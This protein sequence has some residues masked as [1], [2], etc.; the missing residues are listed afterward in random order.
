MIFIPNNSKFHKLYNYISM[1]PQLSLDSENIEDFIFLNDLSYTSTIPTSELDNNIFLEKKRLQREKSLHDYE[2]INTFNTEDYFN[3]IKE[4]FP[5]DAK[6]ESKWESTCEKT[7][8]TKETKEY[9]INKLFKTNKIHNRG[10]KN[11]NLNNKQTHDKYSWDNIITKIQVH[12]ISFIINLA[13]DIIKTVSDEKKYNKTLCFKNIEYKSKIYYNYKEF[14][15][16]KEKCI[17]DILV[18]PAS[19]RNNSNKDNYNEEIYNELINSSDPSE[20]LDEFF[21]IDYLSLTHDYY[22]NCQEL[23]SITIKNKKIELS[24]KTKSFFWLINKKQNDNFKMKK[25]MIECINKVFLK[26]EKK[27]KIENNDSKINLF[28]ITK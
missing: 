22:N 6:L 8:E 25:L 17:K 1:F 13:N 12:Y 9:L 20:I 14:Q 15:T 10:R 24:G 18:K 7:E 16:L 27:S 11:K 2:F 3:D 26:K 19:K 23:K 5:Y 28:N 4:L 21:N